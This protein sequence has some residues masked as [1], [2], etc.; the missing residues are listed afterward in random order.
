MI[1]IKPNEKLLRRLFSN[2][3]S[4]QSFL[5]AGGKAERDRVE[6]ILIKFLTCETKNFCR[7]CAGCKLGANPDLHVYESA[8]LKMEEAKEIER[9]AHKTSW[10]GAKIF[11]IRSD[12]IGTQAQAALLKTIEEPKPGTYFIISISSEGALSP[13]LVSRLT[14]FQLSGAKDGF[15]SAI[16]K[17]LITG[18]AA[19]ELLNAAIFAKDRVK[20]E[21]A[22]MTLELWTEEKIRRADGKEF[23]SLADFLDDLLEIKTRFY[24]KTYSSRMLL[25]HLMISRLYLDHEIR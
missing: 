25:E 11:V 4:A 15:N 20:T 6:E 8:L 24:A 21:E 18:L 22:L 7:D 16:S 9:E 13:P 1:S 2:G 19:K 14:V 10:R 3:F 17:K 23:K 5:L 12:G